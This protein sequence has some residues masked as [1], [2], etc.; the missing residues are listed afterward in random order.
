MKFQLPDFVSHYY[1]LERGPLLSVTNEDKEVAREIIRQ[2]TERNEGFS[3][4]RPTQYIDWRIDVEDWLRKGFIEKGGKPERLNPHYFILGECDWMLG[5]YKNGSVLKKGV[6]ELNP[7]QVT[8][9]YPDSMVSY[10]LYQYHT[11][12]DNPLYKESDH[13]DYHGQVFLL[14][15]LENIISKY[16]L[17]EGGVKDGKP[18]SNEMYIEVQVWENLTSL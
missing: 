11:K 14:E 16:G 1:E 10:Q 6:K 12:R 17:P 4:N 3:N 13:R 5:W 15:E 7:K 2:I 9:T 18:I 8:F